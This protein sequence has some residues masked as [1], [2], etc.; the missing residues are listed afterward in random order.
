ME[1]TIC[2]NEF[3]QLCTAVCTNTHIL[4]CISCIFQIYGFRSLKWC[5]AL[6]AQMFSFTIRTVSKRDTLQLDVNI[7]TQSKGHLQC[8]P[9]LSLRNGSHL[10]TTQCACADF[11]D[12]TTQRNGREKDLYTVSAQLPR[13]R[14]AFKQHYQGCNSSSV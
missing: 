8:R 7:G 9:D 10:P 4:Y 2:G 1:L 5:N 13:R 11:V 6:C 14:G 3:G 12:F